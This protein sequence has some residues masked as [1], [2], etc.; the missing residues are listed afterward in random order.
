LVNKAAGGILKY[1][2][3]KTG[4]WWQVV[5]K[6][7]QPRNY[8]EATCSSMFVYFLAKAVNNGYLPK[9]DI[10]AIRTGYQGLLHQFVTANANGQTID[11]NY[12]CRVATLSR[13]ALGTYQ[14]Y[15][16]VPPVVPNDLKGIGP[17]INAGIECQKLF[18][19]G[20]FSP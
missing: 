14:Y 17:F 18:P 7:G 4:V 9:S 1:Q 15:T 10:P 2:D 6:G 19:T 12:C 8:M 5:D 13:R 11:L 3:P 16:E 20:S